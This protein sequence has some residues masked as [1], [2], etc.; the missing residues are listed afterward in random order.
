MPYRPQVQA[1]A[2]VLLRGDDFRATIALPQNQA[3]ASCCVYVAEDAQPYDSLPGSGDHVWQLRNDLSYQK[4]F[5]DSLSGE[6]VFRAGSQQTGRHD[7]GGLVEAIT[8]QGDTIR[9]PFRSNYRILERK[10]RVNPVKMNVLYIGVDNP[11]E[12]SIPGI[13]PQSIGVS[14][15]N[16]SIVRI[17]DGYRFRPSRP[18]RA[19][20]SV[21]AQID[22]KQ[23][24]MGNQDFRVKRLPNPIATLGGKRG[25]P[26]AKQVLL[27][28]Q[29]VSA[30]LA[31]FDFDARFQVTGFTVSCQL[32]GYK[33]QSQT[34]GNKFTKQQFDLMK[35]LRRG[36]D[37]YIEDIQ[38]VGPDGLIR[39]LS[40]MIFQVR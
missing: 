31:D 37:F 35:R 18:G 26:I 13:D 28:Q 36:E 12:I 25:G 21:W 34:H 33:M 22:G 17:G 3:L 4:L 27:A 20:I 24:A 16:G 7:W 8:L 1:A 39:D 29:G 10:P 38:A 11:I 2:T 19:V 9:W 32:Q 40:P 5:P 14:A 30:S 6:L 23:V 15:V